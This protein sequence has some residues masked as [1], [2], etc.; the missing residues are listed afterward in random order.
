MLNH[1]VELQMKLQQ[2]RNNDNNSNST[3]NDN[4][5]KITPRTAKVNELL[6]SGYNTSDIAY[7]LNMPISVVESEK[8][9][10]ERKDEERIRF[11]TAFRLPERGNIFTIYQR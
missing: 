3:T 1:I 9:M 4:N 11:L 10:V 8:S 2:N 6:E 7:I 5:N